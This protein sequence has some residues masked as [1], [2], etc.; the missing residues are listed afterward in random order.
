MPMSD[1]VHP[2]RHRQVQHPEDHRRPDGGEARAPDAHAE[3][4]GRSS[5]SRKTAWQDITRKL[6]GLRDM[7]ARLSTASRTPSTT[8][9]P[10][11]RTRRP[12]PPPPPARQWKRRSRSLVKQVATADRFL[13]QSLPR[14]F[15]VDAGA[16]H[17]PVG[18]KEVSLAWKGGSLKAFADAAERQGR[19]PPLRLRCE[20]HDRAPRCSSSRGSSPA[21]TNRLTFQDKAADLGVKAGMLQRSPDRQRGRCQLTDKRRRTWTSPSRRRRRRRSRTAPSR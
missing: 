16:V 7:R 20:R 12:S 8:G 3:G 13:S 19:R 10:P 1:F 2:G 14:D 9:W 21:A 17:L 11:P 18:D 15:T 4:A 5:S 6:S